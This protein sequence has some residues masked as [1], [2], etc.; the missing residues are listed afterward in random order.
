[1]KSADIR[2]GFLN[3]FKERGHTVVPASPIVLADDPTLLFVNAGMNQFKDVFLGT[4]KRAY[5][6]AVNA[7]PCIRVS[8]K[9]NDLE[10]VGIDSYHHTCFEMLGNW[11]FGDYYKIESIQWAWELVSGTF[12]IEKDRL[13]ATVY[14]TDEEAKSIWETHTD[15]QKDHIL[16]FGDKENFWEMADTGPCGP[17]SELH[18]DRGPDNCDK[19]GVPGHTCR[20]NGDC[21]RYIEIWNLVFI[22]YNRGADGNLTELPEK[23][24]DTG[25]GLERVTAWLQQV[26]SNYETD[27]FFPI[28]ER[29][30][31]ISGRPYDR[32]AG[33]VPH[34]VMADHSRTLSLAIADHVAPSNEGRGYVLR[35]LLR[36]ALRYSSQ[37]GLNRPVVHQLIAPVVGILGEAYP[38]LK[39]RQSYIEQVVLAEE[40]SFLKTLESGTQRFYDVVNTVKKTGAKV[41]AGQEAFKLYDTYG[42]P[43]DLTQLMAREEGVSVDM[44]GFDTA[45]T[46]QKQQSREARKHKKDAPA[47]TQSRAHGSAVQAEPVHQGVYDREPGGGEAIIPKNEIERF[48]LARHHTGTHLLHAALRAVLGEHAVQAGS[49]VDMDRLRFDFSHFK[50]V[51]EE[52]LTA[53]ESEMNRLIREDIPVTATE[54]AI[55][56]AKAAGAM[57]MFGEK[58][59]D[60]VRV[61]QIGTESME[62][63]GGNH[64][65]HTGAIECMKITHEGA[66]STGV[67]RIEAIAGTENIAKFAT[68][69]T[70]KIQE[71]L[72]VKLQKYEELCKE[73]KQIN[74][75]AT[76]R[77]MALQTLSAQNLTAAET[78]IVEATKTVEKELEKQKSKQAAEWLLGLKDKIRKTKTQLEWLVAELPGAEMA[79]LRKVADQVA[80]E[81]QG[82]RLVVLGSSTEKGGALVVKA[83]R[84]AEKEQPANTVIQKIV[85]TTGGGGGGR[86]DMA[87]AGG[88]DAVKIAAALE[89]LTA[90]LSES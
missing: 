2:Q 11:S 65:T 42:F 9:H 63:C 70:Q 13:Y 18:L 75:H 32:G 84:G 39:K 69:A 7:Q 76:I 57:A 15:I 14:Q 60:Q 51:T 90:E 3:F 71:K 83:V 54:M 46:Q 10:E 59:D 28:I 12:G 58:Y 48:L 43:L 20:V 82:P 26:P 49:W 44:A 85:A 86:P 72:Q 61:I 24:V 19:Q 27:L 8:G 16:K 29:V 35:R 53:I 77:K 73:L 66:V 38:Q 78:E 45:L 89:G 62:L 55:E 30:A 80:S 68:D 37:L 25:M 17:C 56:H 47:H 40:G 6:R 67:R 31:A 23:H 21:S 33:G 41:M 5:T 64:V 79:L 34:R 81:G 1:M 4:G 22:Q 50:K 36:R 52:E 74:P 88:V 87:Q